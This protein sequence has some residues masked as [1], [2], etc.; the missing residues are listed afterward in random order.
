MKKIYIEDLKNHLEKTIILSGWVDSI[1]DLQYVQFI[2]LRDG[3]G[4]VQLTIEKNDHNKELNTL[5]ATLTVESIV[6]VEGLLKSNLNVKLNSMEI[7]PSSIKIDNIA[8]SNLPIN[9]KDKDKTLRETRLDYRFLDLRREDNLLIFKVQTTLE[10]AMREYWINNNFIEIH[11]PKILGA[12]SESGAE[13]FTVDYFGTKAFLAQS[14]QFYKQMAMASGFNKVFEIGPVFRA[15]N[16]HTSYHATEFT[17]I[18]AEISWITSVHDV[19]DMHEEWCKYYMN[20]IIN[21]HAGE[22]KKIF[23]IELEE[24]T[25]K[26]P[27]ITIKEAKE[28]IKE[29]YNYVSNRLDVDR[30]EEELI[31]Q[32]AKEKYNSDFIFLTKFPKDVRPFYHML[33]ED[34]Y[35]ESFD[36][37]YKGIE[38][39]TGAQREHRYEILKK[40]LLN[41]GLLVDELNFYLDFFKYGC[42]PHGGFG[43]G[44]TRFLMKLFDIDNVRE[45]S[46]I[47][48]GPNRLNP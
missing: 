37:L 9:I 4:K 15:E 40:Q 13:V 32:Y 7:I 20:T 34:G 23:N 42:P 2:V 3:T 29:K 39:T 6:T 12:A 41:K 14:P 22:I 5:V 8:D 26:F 18:D 21:K 38:V 16:S 44:L 36:L 45:V 28:I 25:A 10:M 17:G 48:R 24:P 33:D 43:F 1:R 30:K 35:T 19:M 46:Y 47:Y 31:C 27:R 11:S